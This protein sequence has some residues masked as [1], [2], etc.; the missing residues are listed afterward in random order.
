MHGTQCGAG[1]PVITYEYDVA[2]LVV[3]Q[4]ETPVHEL[5]NLLVL[6]EDGVFDIDA[7]C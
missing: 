4:E 7:R 3:G 2:Q 6:L 5:E 1:G